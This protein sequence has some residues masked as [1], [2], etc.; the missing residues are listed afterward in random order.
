LSLTRCLKIY[1]ARNSLQI[2][3]RNERTKADSHSACKR[4]QLRFVKGA[5]FENHGHSRTASGGL[6]GLQPRRSARE[7][8]YEQNALRERNYPNHQR[9]SA[10]LEQKQSPLNN[11]R[12]HV[13]CSRS[14]VSAMLAVGLR[15]QIQD[16]PTRW[17]HGEPLVLPERIWVDDG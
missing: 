13:W 3:T 17:L 2:T 10:I 16:L 14:V 15:T 11:P 7:S 9:R 12:G 4:S 1:N 8:V 5:G 6:R